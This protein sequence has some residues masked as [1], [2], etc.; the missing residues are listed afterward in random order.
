[1]CKI[2]GYVMHCSSP[3]GVR[4]VYKSS[5]CL[6]V[7]THTHTFSQ[8]HQSS[9]IIAQEKSHATCTL[10]YCTVKQVYNVRECLYFYNP[11]QF[12]SINIYT[13]IASLET[14]SKIVEDKSGST[15]Y[16]QNAQMHSSRAVL[17]LDKI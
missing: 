14:L 1:M 4:F 15:K 3:F 5:N 16:K 2:I 10:H 17:V 12:Y 7:S 13:C 6:H 11:L 8:T 9:V